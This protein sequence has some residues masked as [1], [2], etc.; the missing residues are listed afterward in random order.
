M[1]TSQPSGASFVLNS[2]IYQRHF[3]QIR[4]MAC[5]DSTS[6]HME[7]CIS[8]SV[9]IA[10]ATT[11]TDAQNINTRLYTPGIPES[12]H[13]SCPF[14]GGRK[15]VTRPDVTLNIDSRMQIVIQYPASS[16]Q[17]SSDFA[18]QDT[19]PRQ[20]AT[21]SAFFSILRSMGWWWW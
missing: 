19:K 13:S 20:Q 2:F 12:R 1:Q 10:P 15:C 18:I 16:R 14:L 7:G 6:D 9:W 8:P 3:N 5:N 21:F 4:E 11:K 17:H